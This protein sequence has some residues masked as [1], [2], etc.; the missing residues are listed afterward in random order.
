M[1]PKA[2][3]P[4]GKDIIQALLDNITTEEFKGKLVVILGGYA[5]D[6]EVAHTRYM[7]LQKSVGRCLSF[8]C[9]RMS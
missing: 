1:M 4:F 7:L 6:V 2:G 5:R 8:A 3:S 9:T